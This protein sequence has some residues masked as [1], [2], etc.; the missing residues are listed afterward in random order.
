LNSPRYLLSKRVFGRKRPELFSGEE[1]CMKRAMTQRQLKPLLEQ[2]ARREQDLRTRIAD[3]MQRTGTEDYEQLHGVVGDEAD[4]AFVETAV[5]IETG[6]A[7]QQIR[8]LREIEAARERVAQGT[9]GICI[10]CG[11]PIEYERLR[12]YTHAVRCAECQTLHE[13]PG[14]RGRIPKFH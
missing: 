12:I 8:E 9:F 2:L 13:N 6:R 7:E 4:R 3:E 10:D 11:G 1:I 14:A 5:D